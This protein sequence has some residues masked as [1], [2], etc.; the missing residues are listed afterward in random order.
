[1]NVSKT[2]IRSLMSRSMEVC[3]KTEALCIHLAKLQSEVL[4]VGLNSQS[5]SSQSWMK[6]GSD[7]QLLLEPKRGKK[8]QTQ[9]RATN[10]SRVDAVL[11]ELEDIF[12]SEGEKMNNTEA[13]FASFSERVLLLQSLCM[14]STPGTLMKFTSTHKCTFYNVAVAK[15]IS[16]PKAKIYVNKSHEKNADSV[17][18]SAQKTDIS[19][20]VNLIT[21]RV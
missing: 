21:V 10:K 14:G 12:A 8:K 9:L 20:F 7:C 11:S 17:C 5:M 3:L 6:A 19:Y 15:M 1:M 13:L 2:E 16:C 18:A 4:S